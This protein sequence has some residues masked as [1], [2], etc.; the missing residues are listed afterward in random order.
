MG[1]AFNFPYIVLSRQSLNIGQVP[2][3][4]FF[5]IGHHRFS[6]QRRLKKGP[7]DIPGVGGTPSLIKRSMI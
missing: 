5:V 6:F 1:K 7:W 4:P 3:W 2:S